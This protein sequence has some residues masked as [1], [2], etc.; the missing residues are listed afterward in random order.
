MNIRANLIAVVAFAIVGTGVGLA[1]AQQNQPAG[2][3]AP[4][5]SGKPAAT[6]VLPVSP[7]TPS[8]AS[9]AAKNAAAVPASPVAK[10][11][12]AAPVAAAGR[13]PPQPA[14]QKLSQ[15]Q[16]DQ[17]LA[18]V[19]L[20]PDQL[21]DQVLMASGYPLEVVEAARWIRVPAHRRLT[22]NALLAALEAQ[23][24]DPSVMALVRFPRLLAVMSGQP[25]WTEALG[26]AFL[27]QPADVLAAVQSL[28]RDALQ[29]GHLTPAACRCK[30]VSRG[31]AIMIQPANPT[32][33]YVPVCNPTVAY[34]PWPY[35]AYSPFVFPLPVG[36][37]WGPVPYIGFYP[38]VTV[39]W[40]GPLWGWASFDWW[41]ANVIVDPAPYLMLTAGRPAFRGAIWVHDPAHR[42]G[43][44]YS[45]PAVAAR[46]GGRAA[47]AVAASSRFAASAHAGAANRVARSAA[48]V[49]RGII[50]HG[51]AAAAM[52]GRF[53]GGAPRVGGFH[54][55]AVHGGPHMAHIGGFHGGAPRGGGPP[56]AHFSG[57]H[58]GA[59]RGGAPH[60]GGPHDGHGHG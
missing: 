36:Y 48:G 18:P 53:R 49:R 26:N 44:P 58:G 46:F 54:G 19:A 52:H 21:L 10:T 30:V 22:G 14:A 3:T 16:L 15:A 9:P 6:A 35:P 41:H 40:Y 27:A 33:V 12:P 51:A 32:A 28:R 1:A 4:A 59:P 37:V 42:G 55:L 24:W 43:V 7:I 39:A 57:F 56:M 8:S 13:P 38:V 5:A 29:A 25:Q 2:P 34:G 17:L 31:G 11:A 20:Y 23:H 45:D 60:G 50:S 47:L